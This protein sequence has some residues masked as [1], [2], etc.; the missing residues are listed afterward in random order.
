M[1]RLLDLDTHAKILTVEEAL[2][3][4]EQKPVCWV[5]GHFDP[6]LAEHVRRLKSCAT[7]GKL[8]VVEVTNPLQ[9]LLAQRAR[10]ELVAALAMVD[11]VVLS[12]RPPS[13]DSTDAAI[14][15]KFVLHVLS[16]HRKEVGG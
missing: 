16:R 5:S 9:P 7:P 2:Q 15:E 6:L 1:G 10:A 14:T 13:N 11:H 8:L 12:E 4:L 3:R